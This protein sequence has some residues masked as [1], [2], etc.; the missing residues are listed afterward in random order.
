MTAP[1]HQPGA[2]SQNKAGALLG[3]TVGFADDVLT[4]GGI[5]NASAEARISLMDRK[6]P[7]EWVL[8]FNSYFGGICPQ[9]PDQTR[10]VALCA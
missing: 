2:T 9:A 8:N 4:I 7:G 10:L 6:M 3:P 5:P 1:W